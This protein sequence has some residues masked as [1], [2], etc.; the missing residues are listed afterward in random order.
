MQQIT[1]KDML[2]CGVHFGHQTHRW[3]P[4][5]K[6]YVNGARGGIHIIDL[7]KTL[8]AAQKAGEFIKSVAA[9]GGHVIF[10]GTKKQASEPIKEAALKCGQYF[11]IKRWLGGTITNYVTIKASVDRLRKLDIMKQKGDFSFYGKKEQA[12]LEKEFVR[13][14]EY[15]EGIREMKDLPKALFVVDLNKEHIAV[16]EAKR[17]GIP[18]VGIADSNSDPDE[19]E[20]PIPGNDDAIRSIKLFANYAA[21]CYLEGAQKYQE[22]I[23]SESDKQAPEKVESK[24][25]KDDARGDGPSVVK[26]AKRKLVAVGTADDVEIAAE[27][28]SGVEVGTEETTTDTDSE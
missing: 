27:L 6:N 28:E 23:R 2:N 13:L 3:N 19:I 12:Q 17:L 16:A 8:V 5:M 21:E 4:K 1:I 15:L 22:K 24:P 18:V 26:M 14:H 11:V 9:H 25:T 7:Q 20:F 10:V